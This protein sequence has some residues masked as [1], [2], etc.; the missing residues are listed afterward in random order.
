MFHCSAYGG[1][2]SDLVKETAEVVAEKVCRS[3]AE[4]TVEQSAQKLLRETIEEETAQLVPRIERLLVANGE[5][6]IPFVRKTG[7]KGIEA[8]EKAGPRASD[9]L[10]L[11]SRHRDEAIWIVAKSGRMA[12]FLKHGE[13]AASAMLRHGELAETLIER[14]EAPAARALNKLDGQNGRRLAMMA[15]DGDLARI[16]RTREVLDTVGEY[17]DRAMDFIWRN[18]GALTVAT[19]LTTFLADPKPIIAG[20]KDLTGEV[21][22]P[23]ARSINWTL[24]VLTAMGVGLLIVSMKI[25]RRNLWARK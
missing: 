4:D 9:V 6:A 25:V 13:P 12:I 10:K 23:I 7:I 19:A 3:A 16:G 11:F 2:S 21:V 5:E 18:K 24:V 22:T 15:E 14:F 8:L 20:A 1:V 17:G